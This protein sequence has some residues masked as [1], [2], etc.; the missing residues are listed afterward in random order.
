MNT[1]ADLARAIVINETDPDKVAALAKDIEANGWDMGAPAI[2]Y[3]DAGN[4]PNLITGSH[5]CAAAKILDLLGDG[6][7]EINAV[8]VTDAVDAY[9]DEHDC[10]LDEIDYSNLSAIFSGTEYEQEARRNEEW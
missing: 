1:I 10:T 3:Y 4:G 9:C 2:L 7:I 5:R 8:D 6:D